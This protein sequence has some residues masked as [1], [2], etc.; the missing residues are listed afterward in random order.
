MKKLV[1]S[2][3]CFV[4]L[5][6]VVLSLTA[7]TG[8]R[9]R[10]LKSAEEIGEDLKVK[11]TLYKDNPIEITNV[12][13]IR[14]QTDKDQRKDTVYV[15][16]DSETAY[17][18]RR[19]SFVMTYGYYDDIGW[20]YDMHG[21]YFDGE[22][23]LTVTA[24]PDEETVDNWFENK[25]LELDVEYDEWEIEST[26]TEETTATVI[27]KAESS[28]QPPRLHS[29]ITNTEK[30]YIYF[31]LDETGTRWEAADYLNNYYSEIEKVSFSPEVST[32]M[33]GYHNTW[34]A[35]PT[36]SSYELNI[37]SMNIT[38]SG[39]D[40]DFDMDASCKAYEYVYF[41]NGTS[42]H[43]NCSDFKANDVT[44]ER[45]SITIEGSCTDKHISRSYE[46]LFG[47]S[48]IDEWYDSGYKE[49]KETEESSFRI[50]LTPDEMKVTFAELVF[51]YVYKENET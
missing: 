9:F 48:D 38:G 6:S 17:A 34:F 10:H 31:G 23:S 29:L 39:D 18:E 2:A 5:I 51:D 1:K 12:E 24:G 50:S 13:I 22:T 28:Y 33:E 40:F 14:R 8:G 4:L 19:D 15:T 42:D 44:V 46:L 36:E 30:V 21:I 37:K 25:N 43:W 3:L 47:T 35:T 27:C 11:E 16:V 49:T 45:D 20:D 7:C 41:G 32:S 26:E